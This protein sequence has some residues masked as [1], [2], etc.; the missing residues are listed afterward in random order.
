MNIEQRLAESIRSFG[1]D[2]L[3]GAVP[4][5]IV[6]DVVLTVL[7][8]TVCAAM[9][10]R[11]PGYATTTPTSCNDGSCNP[12][13]NPPPRQ[14]DHRR[15]QPAGLLTRPPPSR[16]PYRHRPWWNNRQLNYQFA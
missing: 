3:A 8:H 5:N 16:T 1:L 6:L 13:A 12:A 9:R 2:S 7:V 14:P 10:R 11:L 4:L 15:T